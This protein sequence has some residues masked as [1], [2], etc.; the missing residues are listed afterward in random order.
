MRVNGTLRASGRAKPL[1]AWLDEQGLDV[2][3]IVQSWRMR[4]KQA[5]VSRA[6]LDSL[7]QARR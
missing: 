2:D 3:R 4:D 6:R 1:L 5:M 7:V